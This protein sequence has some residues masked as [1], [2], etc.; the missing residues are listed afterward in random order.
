[1]KSLPARHL[2]NLAGDFLNP[3]PSTPLPVN[4]AT[5]HDHISSIK[6]YN[7]KLPSLLLARPV[8]TVHPT[9]RLMRAI[10]GRLP[11]P[12]IY[13]KHRQIGCNDARTIFPTTQNRIARSTTEARCVGL[14]SIKEITD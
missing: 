1:M 3:Q 13:G 11:T 8:R 14:V 12:V 2:Q 10:T 7:S 6:F 5:P 4:A 9:G